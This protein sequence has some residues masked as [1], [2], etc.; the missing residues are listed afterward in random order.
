MAL[1]GSAIGAL[2]TIKARRPFPQELA[3]SRAGVLLDRQLSAFAELLLLTEYGPGAMP[4]SE[5]KE[6]AG[7]MTD[8]YY[9]EG[10]GLL[11]TGTSMEQFVAARAALESEAPDEEV[12]TAL[13]LLR[14]DLKIELGVRQ[15]SERDVP[16]ARSEQARWK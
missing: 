6:R 1:A 5:R 14:T 15:P 3:L 8:W 13:S 11:L 2:A 16:W 4:L 12:R 9:K 7:K 10:A